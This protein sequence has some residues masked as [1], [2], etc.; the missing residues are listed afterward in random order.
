MLAAFTKLNALL[1]T[2]FLT[3]MHSIE[4]AQSKVKLHAIHVLQQCTG[5][6]LGGPP[7]ACSVQQHIHVSKYCDDAHHPPIAAK[8]Q[9]LPRHPF[10][11]QHN[12]QTHRKPL[13]HAPAP[14]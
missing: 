14:G 6:Q 3:A 4:G 12:D 7:S 11:F 2:L 9:S 1:G 5:D 13:Q 10:C 8:H